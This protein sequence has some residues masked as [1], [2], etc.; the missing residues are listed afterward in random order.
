VFLATSGEE[1]G[2]K[3]SSAWVEEHASEVQPGDLVI[4]LDV[5]WSG[6]GQYLALATDDALRTEAMAA[7]EA[8]GV[9]VADGGSPGIGSDHVAFVFRGARAVWL[10]R[11][12]DR[13]Y[14]TVADTIDA[15]DFD[16][17]AA[18]LR[19]NWRL[20]AAHAGIE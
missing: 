2:L 12:P 9:V 11:W 4:V 18:A 7:A 17:A 16:E 8:E 3:G 15:L 10:G 14:H 6:E 1:Q 5:M 19:T 13:H 20:L